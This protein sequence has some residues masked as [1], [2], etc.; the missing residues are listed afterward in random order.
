MSVVSTYSFGN[1]PSG[2][3]LG[4]REAVHPAPSQEV[5]FAGDSGF[6]DSEFD[7]AGFVVAE[8]PVS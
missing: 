5:P 7:S 2:W 3:L 1:S 8:L 4:H 6:K